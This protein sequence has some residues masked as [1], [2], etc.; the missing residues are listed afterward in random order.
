MKDDNQLILLEGLAADVASL[1]KKL[2]S[3]KPEKN[4]FDL[5]PLLEEVKS[6]KNEIQSIRTTQ[7]Q[8]NNADMENDQQRLIDLRIQ[9]DR[10]ALKLS[11]EDS[12][13]R[14]YLSSPK[15]ILVT[16]VIIVSSIT[17]GVVGDRYYQHKKEPKLQSIEHE[18]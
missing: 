10:I 15:I 4:D 8:Q 3:L 12:L 6:L 18:N 16:I 11:R 13:L 2:S 5:N 17:I 14:Y 7:I 9:I 1:N